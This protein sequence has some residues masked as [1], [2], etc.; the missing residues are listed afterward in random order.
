M[1]TFPTPKRCKTLGKGGKWQLD[2][3]PVCKLRNSLATWSN[4]CWLNYLFLLSN[5]IR[6]VHTGTEPLSS[7]WSDC[8]AVG[9][10]LEKQS[11]IRLKRTSRVRVRTALIHHSDSWKKVLWD[12][13]KHVSNRWLTPMSE[14]WQMLCEHLVLGQQQSSVGASNLVLNL[15]QNTY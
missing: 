6:S 15:P 2:L 7:S 1:W 9:P 14:P 11:L 4:I 8:T 12:V 3:S 13:I 5:N 10:E